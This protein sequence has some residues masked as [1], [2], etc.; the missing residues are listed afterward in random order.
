MKRYQVL[1]NSFVRNQSERRWESIFAQFL[2]IFP[3]LLH[4]FVVYSYACNFVIGL[5]IYIKSR[6]VR[7][8]PSLSHQRFSD[9]RGGELHVYSSTAHGHYFCLSVCLLII[10]NT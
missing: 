4:I 9:D 5:S 1:V 3:S 2:F 8:V 7:R 6:K 10:L